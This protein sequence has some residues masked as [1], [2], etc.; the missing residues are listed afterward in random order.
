MTSNKTLKKFCKLSKYIEQADSDLYEVFDDLCIM[1]LLKPARG[2]AGIT[3]LFPKEKAYRQKIVK[4]AYSG[5]PE[6]AVNMIKALILQDYYPNFA[7]FGSKAIN[8]LNQK[9]VVD[10]VSDKGIKLAGG[11]EITTDTKF[12]PMGYRE[13]MAVYTL[14]GKGEMSL[15]NPVTSV[16]HKPLKSGGSIFGSSVKAS[17]HKILADT[18]VSEIGKVENVYVKKVYLQLKCLSESKADMIKCF[19][20]NDEFSDS[21]LLDMYCEA[22]QPDCLVSLVKCF[23]PNEFDDKVAKITKA[24]YVTM[25]ETFVDPTGNDKDVKDPRRLDGIMSPM[26]IRMRVFQLYNDDKERIGKD[27]FIVFCNINRDLWNTDVDS[28]GAF[29]N[30]AYLAAN[31]YT[32]C[33]DIV[34]QEFDI[35][36]DLTL[37][38]NLLK[39]DVFH[40]VPQASFTSA[41]LPVPAS[42]PSPLD[43]SLYSLCGFINVM[44]VNNKTGGASD[45]TL[46]YLLGDL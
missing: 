41:P 32:K 33:S 38:G 45:P 27:L 3:L 30:F 26:E 5:E 31:V 22:Y 44:S 46:S 16:E 25:K 4:A 23:T 1:H 20:G 24:M 34:K 37:Y 21:Y 29:K 12:V 14:S 28:I 42:L 9:L 17:L 6:I 13:N 36:R 11:L 10:S 19:L 7:S 43:I 35:P 8:L 39:S 18:Y 15:T 2:A 40:Y